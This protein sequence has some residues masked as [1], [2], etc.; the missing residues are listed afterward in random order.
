MHQTDLNNLPL[1]VI[2]SVFSL[3]AA[4]TWFAGSSLSKYGVAIADRI[5]FSRSLMGLFIIAAATSLPELV[6]TIVG[7]IKGQANLILND[8]F[9]GISMQTAILALAD[10]LTAAA[11]ISF[12]ALQA[13]LLLE[14]SLLI[15][16][17]SVTLAIIFFQDFIVIG[18]IGLGCIIVTLLYILCIVILRQY[19]GKKKWTPTEIPSEE[20]NKVSKTPG[21]YIDHK[22]PLRNLLFTFSINVIIV[23]ICGVILVYSSISIANKTGLGES[24]IGATLLAAT[25]SLPELSVTI[26][27]ASM[28]AY[29]MAISNIFG[30]NMIMLALIL[31]A[32]LFYTQG[33]ILQKADDS[34]KF[35]IISGI[36]LT[37]IYLSGLIIRSKKSYLKMGIDSILVIIFYL[38]SLV[39]FYHLK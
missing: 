33:A 37:S 14:A 12:I 29:G 25:T 15:L 1:P 28:G 17:L 35:A 2:L 10:M 23:L 5:K 11:P 22:K 16:M 13:S 7:A 39:I 26:T 24:F 4:G 20:I 18:W 32:E 21:V 38:L 36:L 8:M 30:S 19:E 31:P 34:T 3:A 27:A 6:I 9:G